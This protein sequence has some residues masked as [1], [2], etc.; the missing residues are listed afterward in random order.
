MKVDAVAS[1]ALLNHHQRGDGA[2]KERNKSIIY[3]KAENQIKFHD[4]LIE[5]QKKY[6]TNSALL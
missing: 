3:S 1:C 4:V 2:R 5:A 6:C